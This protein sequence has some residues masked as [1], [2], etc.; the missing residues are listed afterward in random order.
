[1][2]R[3]GD[4]MA[5]LG[6][7]V[8]GARDRNFPSTIS[9]IQC[10]FIENRVQVNK[11]IFMKK[12]D[13][14]ENRT[15]NHCFSA[16]WKIS[17]TWESVWMSHYIKFKSILENGVRNRFLQSI[18][19][20]THK[21]WVIKYKKTNPNGRNKYVKPNNPHYKLTSASKGSR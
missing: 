13:S 1:M 14:R 9:K 11:I 7:P 10:W 21:L 3:E 15:H 18:D 5:L 19:C 4:S 20:M 16:T 17:K 6:L 2:H 8:D 12:V